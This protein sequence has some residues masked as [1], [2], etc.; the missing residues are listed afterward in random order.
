MPFV[1]EE[2]IY[3]WFLEW[4]DRS[5]TYAKKL[6]VAYNAREKS[7]VVPFTKLPEKYRKELLQSPERAIRVGEAAMVKW[8]E[9]NV[10]KKDEDGKPIKPDTG[11]WGANLRIKSLPIDTGRMPRTIDTDDISKLRAIHG[12]VNRVVEIM[13]RLMVGAFACSS[14]GFKQEIDQDKFHFTEPLE[15]PKDDGGCGKRAGST[16]FKF[17][18]HEALWINRQKVELQDVPEMLEGHEQAYKKTLYIED[19]LCNMVQPGD[20]VNVTSVVKCKQRHEGKSKS[21]MFSLYLEGNHISNERSITDIEITPEEIE[22]FEKFAKEPGAVTRLAS[23]IASS[24]YGLEEIKVAMVLAVTGAPTRIK[25]DG[26]PR[27]GEIHLLIVGDPGTGKSILIKFIVYLHPRGIYASGKSSSGAG[28]TA[29]VVKDNFGEGNYTL[30]GGVMVLADGGVAAIDEMDK[31]TKEDTSNMHECM[32]HGT[33]TISKVIKATLRAQTTVIGAA[34]PKGGAFDPDQVIA[35][36]IDL[37]APLQSRFSMIFAIF[38]EPKVERDEDLALH[39]LDS[40]Y[41]P[42]SSTVAPEL[43]SEWVMKYI[44][45]AKRFE[46]IMPVEIRE[47]LAK[48]YAAIRAPRSFGHNLHV[49]QERTIT[50]RQLEDLQRLAEAHARIRLS[51]VV[52][53]QDVELAVDLLEKSLKQITAGEDGTI[54]IVTLNTGT[55]RS[56]RE[57]ETLARNVMIALGAHKEPVFYENVI[58]DMVAE[59]DMEETEAKQV[60]KGLYKK[61]EI[62][63]PK[64]DGK[65]KTVY[66]MGV[67]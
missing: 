61:N 62:T 43:P 8:I 60:L 2:I 63:Y 53:M 10:W 47:E 39:N 42:K 23:S 51:E 5:E 21:S 11:L 25:S 27:R 18:I 29:A 40:V 35:P 56:V 12:I 55:P 20:R 19:D 7:F 13:P 44:W 34:N 31:M 49:K 64:M 66:F 28:L 17:M 52:E 37:P 38:D 9:N 50:V 45:Y 59:S 57:K 6:K 26:T 41:D 1:D 22:A 65:D 32:E 24:L 16:T 58:N 30:E 33:I 36:Q 46:P 54:D 67:D 4:L 14:C 48:R 3:Q 15:C